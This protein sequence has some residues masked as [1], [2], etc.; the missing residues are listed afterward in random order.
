MALSEFLKKCRSKQ[1]LFQSGVFIG[2]IRETLHLIRKPALALRELTSS[3]VQK[4]RL[5]VHRYNRRERLRLLSNQWLEYSFGA[6][7][8]IHD[9]SDAAKALASLQFNFPQAIVKAFAVKDV[10]RQCFVT[11]IPVAGG[12]IF[13]NVDGSMVQ[14]TRRDI[15]G[16]VRLSTDQDPNRLR[17]VIGAR[18]PDFIPTFYELIPYSFLVDYFTNIGE[19]LE[20]SS[21]CQADLIWHTDSWHRDVT[22][23]LVCNPVQPAPSFG[24]GKELLSSEIPPCQ[25][26]YKVSSFT[27]S[28]DPL[29]VPSLQFKIP[30]VGS[31][32]ALNIAALA[33]LRV[34]R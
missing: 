20:A 31:P 32:K 28:G 18:L 7:P 11:K 33:H 22:Q 30:R 9:V 17:A 5:S 21:F 26:T 15:K 6:K 12:Y 13:Y 19:I 14:R 25:S 16:A 10:S 27:R 34:L 23:T 1:R 2:E 3:Y 29:G 24:V 8:L 4:V